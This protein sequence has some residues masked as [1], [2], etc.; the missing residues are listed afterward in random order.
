MRRRTGPGNLKGAGWNGDSGRKLRLSRDGLA[1]EAVAGWSRR[2]NAAR[3]Q[4]LFREAGL[5]TLVELPVEP[6]GWYH[7][8]NQFVIRTPRRDALRE[9]LMA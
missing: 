9:H 1:R 3:Y 7:I 8:Y 2:R 4:D 6:A 5:T